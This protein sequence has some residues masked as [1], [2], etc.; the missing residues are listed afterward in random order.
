MSQN[1][2]ALVVEDDAH[3]LM[4]ITTILKEMNICCK[5]NTA[6]NDVV[7]QAQSM[8]PQ[9]DFIMLELDLMNSDSWAVFRSLQDC[10]LTAHIP[11]IAVGGESWLTRQDRI[12]VAGFAGFLNKPL[13]RSQCQSLIRQVLAGSGVW[14]EHT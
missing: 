6:G 2:W 10:P 1:H 8:I 12:R 13:P 9:L 3:Q 14:E 5:R 11:I 4:V 7:R